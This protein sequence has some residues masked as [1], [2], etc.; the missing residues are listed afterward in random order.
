LKP[1]GE[2]EVEDPTVGKFHPWKNG[3]MEIA[4]WVTN[5]V[6]LLLVLE[7]GDRSWNLVWKLSDCGCERGGRG[8]ED[9]SIAA[10][11]TSTSSGNFES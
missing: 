1:A 3:L 4:A 2:V 6:S 10:A 11:T 9:H 8:E 7:A 5:R